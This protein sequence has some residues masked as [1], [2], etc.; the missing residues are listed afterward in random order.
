MEHSALNR[1]NWTRIY[2]NRHYLEIIVVSAMENTKQEC[3]YL[4]KKQQLPRAKLFKHVEWSKKHV[5]TLIVSYKQKCIIE[6]SSTMKICRAMIAN[7]RSFSLSIQR[8]NQISL[9]L[10]EFFI[11]NIPKRKKEKETRSN[12]DVKS[13]NCKIC[14]RNLWTVVPL[15]V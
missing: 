11:R 13:V 14:K 6:N 10:F 5:K 8:W 2:W 9:F 12:L 3:K 4:L 1:S 7:W 15:Q